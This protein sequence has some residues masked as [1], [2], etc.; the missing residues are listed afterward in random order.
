MSRTRNS[1]Y[2]FS[3]GLIYAIVSAVVGL[4]A[5]PWLLIWLGP[6][7][8]GAFK[9][10]T[11]WMGYLTFF[12]LGMGGAMMAAFAMKIGQD[13]STAVS[14]TIAAGLRVYSHVMLASLTGGIALLAAI[15][16]V[17]PSKELWPGELR[18]SAAITLLSLLL[19][20]LLVFRALAEARQRS[21]IYWLLLTVQ[22]VLITG[23]SMVMAWAGWGLIGQTLAWTV[24]QAP[25]LL[26]L[27][28]DCVRKYGGTWSVSS[29]RADRK[30]L[31]GL[32][33]ST[34]AH[35]M[36]DRVGLVGDN[37]VI[38]WILGPAAL[39]PF[40]LT[41]HLVTIALANLKGISSATWAGLAELY[42]RSE[43]VAF[44]QRLLELTGMISGLGVAI[45]GPVAVYNRFFVRQWIGEEMYAG[46]AVTVLACFN[47]LAW[48]VYILWGWVILGTGNIR[49]WVPYSV[50]ATLVNIVISVIGT[51]TLGV[52]GPLIGS[53]ASMLLVVS[54]SLPSLLNRVF[55]ISPWELW[56]AVFIPLR[57][58]AIYLALMC[59][60]V[61]RFPPQGWLELIMMMGIWGCAGVILWWKL[62]LG[63]NDRIEWR[64]R[65][66]RSVISTGTP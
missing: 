45:L 51:F 21:Y 33:R 41:Q 53:A 29:N 32:G 2:N 48:S 34:F 1:I 37:I 14:R 7:R 24:S 3:A 50:V 58:G 12:D 4:L 65:L 63:K 44:R 35:M 60:F 42:S 11:D 31:W 61:N 46:E 57:W 6:E 9:A 22:I 47:T 62:S 23:L 66:R 19:T 40:F 49:L 64:D 52:I 20:P 25:A 10:L 30:A 56:R 39:A 15:P 28:W 27:L 8:L 38:A 17:I 5:T 54:W 16:I 43:L 36:A 13:D 18:I 26:V 59:I 55:G